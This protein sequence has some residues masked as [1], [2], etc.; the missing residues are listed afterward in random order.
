M[1]QW[2]TLTFCHLIVTDKHLISGLHVATLTQVG[3]DLLKIVASKISA[4]KEATS[5]QLK[6]F[7][8][9]FFFLTIEKIIETLN[10]TTN[11][12][13]LKYIAT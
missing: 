2:Q 8:F 6:T 4:L 1:T 5:S 7:F 13:L 12:K 3:D 9:F 11:G 10:N